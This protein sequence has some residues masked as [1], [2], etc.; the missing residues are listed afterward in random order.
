MGILLQTDWKKD[1]FSAIEN[2]ENPMILARMKSGYAVIGDTQ[3]LPGYCVLLAYPE[4]NSL[5]DLSLQGRTNFLRD[6]S[7]LGEAVQFVCSPRRLNYSIYGNSDEFLHAHVFPRYDWE[8]EERSLIQSGSIPVKC[9]LCRQ[10][11]TVM[12]NICH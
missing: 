4:V 10:Y 12:K 11:N 8:P 5:E 9:G 2:H 1:R 6:M 3:F 7:L